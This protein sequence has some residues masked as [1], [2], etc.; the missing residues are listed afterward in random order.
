M[1]CGLPS[2]LTCIADIQAQYVV[3]TFVKKHVNINNN[4]LAHDH[5][6]CWLDVLNQIEKFE[7]L[8]ACIGLL[9]HMSSLVTW[10]I[11]P[12]LAFKTCIGFCIACIGFY[13]ACMCFCIACI[14]SCG[15]CIGYPLAFFP[16]KARKLEARLRWGWS[17]NQWLRGGSCEC[18]S[19]FC[20]SFKTS[21]H[22]SITTSKGVEV[23]NSNITRSLME[24]FRSSPGK[25]RLDLLI[26]LLSLCFVDT[27]INF[28]KQQN[29]TLH[30]ASAIMSHKEVA[31]TAI[32][33]APAKPVAGHC[34]IQMLELDMLGT[35]KPSCKSFSSFYRIV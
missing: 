13:I 30:C 2:L 19:L 27:C 12:E 23:P 1:S 9:L 15:A 26:C 7:H 18:Q 34:H 33:L 16:D 32:S 3:N 5:V 29:Y 28:E 11:Q 4:T 25:T 8:M 10:S 6:H 24:S 21:Q 20:S 14:A 22:A 31:V 17:Q 35:A